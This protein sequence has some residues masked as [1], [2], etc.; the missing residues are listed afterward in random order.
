MYKSQFFALTEVEQSRKHRELLF[1][2]SERVK[3]EHCLFRHAKIIAPDAMS[4]DLDKEGFTKAFLEI[5][6]KPL[7]SLG[8]QVEEERA[9]ILDRLGVGL[10]YFTRPNAK[11]I[12]VLSKIA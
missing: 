12:R 2:L 1:T 7:E 9:D 8:L 4:A 11:A 6:S 10:C 3:V 5:T